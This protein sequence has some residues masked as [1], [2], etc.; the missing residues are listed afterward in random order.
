MYGCEFD[1]EADVRQVC[2]R[3]CVG[4]G[5]NQAGEEHRNTGEQEVDSDKKTQEV[6]YKRKQEITK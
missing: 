1:V 2:V 5:G 6:S 3:V 4:G